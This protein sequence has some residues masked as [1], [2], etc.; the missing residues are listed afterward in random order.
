LSSN[1]LEL[2]GVSTQQSNN[3]SEV[4]ET[5]S[6]PYLGKKCVKV[7]KS[8]PE[9]SIG[10]CS[11]NQGAKNS[12]GII[13]CPHRFLER[14]QIFMDCI[15]L[16]TLHEP[17]NEVHRIAEVTIPGGNVDYFL[18]SVKKGRVVDFVGIELQAIDTTGTIW[19]ERQKFLQA[20]G[21]PTTEGTEITKPYGMNWKMT[22]KTT[23]VQLHHKI[24]TFEQLGKH[25][26]IVLQEALLDY[27][28]KEFDF[29]QIREV[30]LGDSMHFH[31]YSL[32]ESTDQIRLN[33]T[34]RV[35]TDAAGIATCLGLQVS[36]KVE[37]EIILA[38][39]Q[40]KISDRTL[41]TI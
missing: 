24:E 23:L 1:I 29:S 14:K 12:K 6:C 39:L 10:T 7:R 33:L 11:V 18:T 20:V 9:I 3:W 22:A 4:V 31:A 2:F 28:R 16:L 19:P 17:G 37:L 40:S 35:S 41:L 13:I 34:S 5:Q 26:V 36:P 30:L 15:H 8:Q 25:L 38:T 21:F 27:M 32:Q